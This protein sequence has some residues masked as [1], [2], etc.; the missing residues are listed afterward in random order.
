MG[1]LP[2]V[3]ESTVLEESAFSAEVGVLSQPIL[4]ETK[5]KQVGYWLVEVIEVDD[6]VDPIKAEVRRILVGSEQEAIDIRDR[7]EA[8]EDFAELAA[9]F[10]LDTLSNAEGGEIT[11]SPGVSTA[12]FEDYVFD[13]EVE[14]GV[15]SQPIRDAEGSSTGGY[16]L[17]KVVASEDNREIDEEN[18]LILKNDTLNNW[19]EGLRDNPENIIV[20]NLDE[21]KK[22]WAVTYVMGG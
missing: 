14:L 20:N 13:P 19:V 3:V 8:G 2:L 4:E 22:Q 21:E 6:T 11:L 10:S 5:T 1:V 17:I 18:R 12:A 16:W 15:L 7:L 9:E